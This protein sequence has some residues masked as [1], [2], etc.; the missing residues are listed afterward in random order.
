[1]S[2]ERYWGK[3]RVDCGKIGQTFWVKGQFSIDISD[4]LS[5]ELTED[6]YTK[7]KISLS[8]VSCLTDRCILSICGKALKRTIM[9]LSCDVVH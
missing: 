9:F 1:M 7:V 5:D 2:G 6:E 3:Q 4:Q 8:K